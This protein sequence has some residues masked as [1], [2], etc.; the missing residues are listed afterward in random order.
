[1]SNNNNN[2]KLANVPTA[3]HPQH[4]SAQF[5]EMEQL[6]LMQEAS[7]LSNSKVGADSTT[8]DDVVKLSHQ[9][10]DITKSGQFL[11]SS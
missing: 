7:R 10:T 9:M 6:I 4:A 1:M 8:N 5:R 3:L 2:N 11:R